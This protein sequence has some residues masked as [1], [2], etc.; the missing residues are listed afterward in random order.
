MPYD[1]PLLKGAITTFR[2][3]DGGGGGR[4]VLEELIGLPTSS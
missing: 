4:G 2:I 1:I 3:D